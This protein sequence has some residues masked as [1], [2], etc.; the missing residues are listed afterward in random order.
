MPTRNNFTC[1]AQVGER[2]SEIYSGKHNCA[3]VIAALRKSDVT[4]AARHENSRTIEG[5]SI[6]RREAEQCAAI[7]SSIGQ[8]LDRVIDILRYLRQFR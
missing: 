1:P 4:I 8:R 3:I 7:V 2:S 5:G 6:S